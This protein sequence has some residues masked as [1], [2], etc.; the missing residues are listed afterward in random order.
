M[1]FNYIHHDYDN[2][3]RRIFARSSPCVIVRWLVFLFLLRALR[4][5]HDSSSISQSQ[6]ISC[7]RNSFDDSHFLVLYFLSLH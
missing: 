1:M 4:L 3:F 2:G 7:I 5:S 6:L